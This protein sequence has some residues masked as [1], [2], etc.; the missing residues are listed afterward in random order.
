M[1]GIEQTAPGL[2]HCRTIRRRNSTREALTGHVA[3]R[4]RHA[5]AN[6]YISFNVKLSPAVFLTAVFFKAPLRA[7][8]NDMRD[9]WIRSGNSSAFDVNHL[10]LVASFVRI[11]Q[12]YTRTTTYELIRN[13]SR[14][15]GFVDIPLAN[16]RE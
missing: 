5:T 12:L 14:T 1:H 16:Q 8:A 10:A 9:S 3:V 6:G 4:C 7:S 2:E 15:F 11:A 13:V